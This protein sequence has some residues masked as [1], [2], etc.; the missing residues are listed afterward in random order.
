MIYSTIIKD[1]LWWDLA[2]KMGQ[3]ARETVKERFPIERFKEGFQHSIE[4]ARQK[5]EGK[6]SILRQL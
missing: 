1:G 5:W 6:R 2:E 3:R 4:I